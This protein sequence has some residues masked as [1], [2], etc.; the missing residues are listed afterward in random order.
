MVHEN[1]DVVVTGR[2]GTVVMFQPITDEAREWVDENVG[3]EPWQWMG[4]AF[5]V[6]HRFVGDL[7]EGMEADGLVVVW[8]MLHETNPDQRPLVCSS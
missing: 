8:G 7:I 4:P 3:L 6:E 5:A 2:G 1:P